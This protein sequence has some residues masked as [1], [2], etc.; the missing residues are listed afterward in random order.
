M[1]INKWHN[2]ESLAGTVVLVAATVEAVMALMAAAAMV[3]VMV[4]VAPAAAVPVELSLHSQ[5]LTYLHICNPTATV[6]HNQKN[7]YT[8][9]THRRG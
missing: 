6:N 5:V 7:I 8:C 9:Q 2:A 1:G 3:V 4:V